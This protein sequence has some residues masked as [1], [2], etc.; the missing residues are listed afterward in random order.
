[1]AL[2]KSITLFFLMFLL[3]III[4]SCKV[5][6]TPEDEKLPPEEFIPTADQ[7]REQTDVIF[8]TAFNVTTN[9]LVS[10][11][12]LKDQFNVKAM[13]KSTGDSY[14]FS[15]GTYT[16][17]GLLTNPDW[18]NEYTGT[19]LKKMTFKAFDGGQTVDNPLSANY[20]ELLVNV[21]EAFGFINGD[22]SGDKD[23][24]SINGSWDGL[25]SSRPKYTGTGTIERWWNGIFNNQKVNLHYLVEL[26]MN[27]ISYEVVKN[28]L[29]MRG[30]IVIVFNPYKV[31]ISCNGSP[32][33]PA[34]LFI[35]NQK[36]MDFEVAVPQEFVVDIDPLPHY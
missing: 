19:F 30:R 28:N 36:Q 7:V 10:Y 12:D 15:N 13:S 25:L 20:M 29:K 24:R 14:S 18:V 22:P 17:E 6:V 23:E 8:K 16:W 4:S 32:T 26:K 21:K 11:K 5:P 35:R 27:N 34:E 3:G 33:A 9:S 2:N 31:I 1:M